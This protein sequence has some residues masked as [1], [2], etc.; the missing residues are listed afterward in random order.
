L[1]RKFEIDPPFAETDTS[2]LAKAARN[3]AQRDI[4][5]ACGEIQENGWDL[6]WMRRVG[7][8]DDAIASCQKKQMILWVS[9]LSKDLRCDGSRQ[10]GSPPAATG[11]P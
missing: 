3:I 1:P 6:V 11:R 9:A 8:L 4:A 10:A 7:Q 5:K 2:P